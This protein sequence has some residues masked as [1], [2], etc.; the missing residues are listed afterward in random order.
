[1]ITC[2][3]TAEAG[4]KGV[5]KKE[6]LSSYAD[7]SVVSRLA[8]PIKQQG[9]RLYINEARALFTPVAASSGLTYVYLGTV[10]AQDWFPAPEI[11]A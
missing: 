4:R 2:P 9:G 3:P 5:E 1:M 7:A 11:A 6:R 10:A 8:R